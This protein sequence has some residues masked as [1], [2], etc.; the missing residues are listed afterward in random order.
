MQFILRE[1][2]IF[3]MLVQNIVNTQ[4]RLQTDIVL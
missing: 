4:K 3:N 2:L 1:T